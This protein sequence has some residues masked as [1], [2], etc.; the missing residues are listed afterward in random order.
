MLPTIKNRDIIIYSPLTKSKKSIEE[1]DLVVLN[2]PIKKE[3]LI[4][5]R[6]V[7]KKSNLIDLR[8]DNQYESSDSRDFGMVSKKQILG[9]VEQI[10][11][12]FS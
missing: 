1:G 6:V 11:S 9:K 4:I 7:L 2:H 3:T 10:I 8:G 12:I 5:K